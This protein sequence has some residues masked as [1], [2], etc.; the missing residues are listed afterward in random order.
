MLRSYA[1]SSVSPVGR[2]VRQA[3]GYSPDS[4]TPLNPLS[5]SHRRHLAFRIGSCPR[6]PH[7]GPVVIIS[8]GAD[9]IDA[10]LREHDLGGKKDDAETTES[11]MGSAGYA[12]NRPE[13]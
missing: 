8:T 11:A 4:C 9:D 10:L 5:V 2:E 7:S 6:K 12:E 3:S 13:T 1:T